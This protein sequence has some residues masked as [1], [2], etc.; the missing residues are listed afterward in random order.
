MK[1]AC[2]PCCKE[3]GEKIDNINMSS[4]TRQYFDVYE[5]Q[6]EREDLNIEILPQGKKREGTAYVSTLVTVRSPVMFWLGTRSP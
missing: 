4:F 2:S 1:S 3:C 6:R 5:I